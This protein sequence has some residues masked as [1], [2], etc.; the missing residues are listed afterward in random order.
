M[1]TTR[2]NLM[3]GGAS[4]AA[5]AAL[6]RTGASRAQ[7]PV[8]IT[9]WHISVVEAEQALFQQLADAYVEQHPN[10]EI[11]ITVL[12][13]EAFKARLTTA[14][15]SG[16]PTDI[17]QSWGGGVLYEYAA[18]GLVKDITADLETDGWGDSFVPA[19]LE[20]YGQ[21]GAYYGVPWRL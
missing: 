4:A 10:V 12:E 5:V 17:F 3:I 9:W 6:S 7:E 15:Q 2:R 18:A 1:K 8:T 21:N 19:G 20:L 14:M 16:E 11:E 13:N